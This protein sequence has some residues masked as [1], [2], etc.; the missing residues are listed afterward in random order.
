M[1][2]PGVCAAERGVGCQ[3]ETAQVGE[4]GRVAGLEQKKHQKTNSGEPG[5]GGLGCF[6]SGSKKRHTTPNQTNPSNSLIW[7]RLTSQTGEESGRLGNKPYVR[8]ITE[9]S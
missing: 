4:L 1:A 9:S 5:G 8:N 6:R 2:A 7:V 3:E